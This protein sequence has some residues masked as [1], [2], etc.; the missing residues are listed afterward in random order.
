MLLRIC[1]GFVAAV[2]LATAAPA[3]AARPESRLVLTYAG[4]TGRPAAVRLTCDPDGGEHPKAAQACA[5]LGRVGA[6]PR[7][8]K[9]ADRLCFMLYQPVTAQLRGTWRGRPVKWTQ[10]FGNGCEMTRAT[11]VLFAF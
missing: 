11:G 5:E 6:D 10:R 7:R 2:V 1:T 3:A 8:L 4:E 9:P